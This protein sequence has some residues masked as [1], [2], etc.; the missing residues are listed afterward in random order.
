ME[1]ATTSD[2]TAKTSPD[3]TGNSELNKVSDTSEKADKSLSEN[4]DK[5]TNP[6][7]V[8]DS[9]ATVD[10]SESITSTNANVPELKGIF[11]ILLLI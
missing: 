3:S 11:I 10:A 2:G 6:D 4:S 9:E 5:L 8:V 7:H 1:E